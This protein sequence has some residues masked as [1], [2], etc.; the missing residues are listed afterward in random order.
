MG[1]VP[2][3]TLIWP[4]LPQL[5]RH[6]SWS[7][8][9]QAAGF[10]VLLNLVLLATYGWTEWISPGVRVVGWLAVGGWWLSAVVRTMRQKRT[11]VQAAAESRDLFPDAQ[12]EYLRG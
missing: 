9:A 6:G 1:R 4:G 7:G 11:A 12:R 5:W 10:A 3:S 8:L 2:W